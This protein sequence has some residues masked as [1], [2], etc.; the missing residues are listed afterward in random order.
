MAFSGLYKI[1][2]CCG[3]STSSLLQMTIYVNPVQLY[4]QAHHRFLNRV[5]PPNFGVLWAV[6]EFLCMMSVC[7]K[8][9]SKRTKP[10]NSLFMFIK[11]V[12]SGSQ[13]RRFPSLS[14]LHRRPQFLAKNSSGYLPRLPG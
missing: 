5:W 7:L 2:E 11:S 13:L 8:I 1:D 10:Y 9:A 14:L 12:A 4:P 3:I 6:F